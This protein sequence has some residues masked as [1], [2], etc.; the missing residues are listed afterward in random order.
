M[1]CEIPWDDWPVYVR[2]R[3]HGLRFDPKTRAATVHYIET[4]LYISLLCKFTADAFDRLGRSDDAGFFREHA[5]R[6]A[7]LVADHCWDE[8]T[9][10]YYDRDIAPA[11]QR[12]LVKHLGAFVAMLMG[13]PSAKQ[14]RRLVEHLTNPDEFWTPYPAPTISKDSLDY[15]PTHYWSGRAWPPTNFFVLRA[16]LNYGFFDVADEYL[17]RWM[18]H[19]QTCVDRPVQDA[20]LDQFDGI[21]L[22]ARRIHLP[23]IQWIVPE[24]WNPETGEVIG[25][26]GVTWGGLWLPAIIFRHFWPVWHDRVLIRP[27]G[28]FKF[29]WSDRWDI[30]IDDRTAVVNGRRY[31]LAESATYLLDPT[32]GRLQPLGPGRADP[33]TF[34][35]R[36][37]K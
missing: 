12:T 28:S 36:T 9:G 6:L 4:Q 19:V 35:Y 29:T 15:A 27:G 21:S 37:T 20:S 1:I 8:T 7:Q 14:A 25:S 2:G 30:E 23:G 26:G 13:L 33:V 31:R 3:N 24:N 5:R 16:L 10:F 32:S 11:G 17:R 18:R 22:D 34:D